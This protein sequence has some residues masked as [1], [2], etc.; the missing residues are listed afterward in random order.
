MK[1]LYRS[2]KNILLTGV[3]GGIGEYF[4]I[5]PVVVRIAFL[6]FLL[7]TGVFPGVIIYLIALILMPKKSDTPTVIDIE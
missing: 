2:E 5:D 7:L 1:K 4:G 3:L 6:I